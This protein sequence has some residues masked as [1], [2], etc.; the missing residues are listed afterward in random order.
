MLAEKSSLTF[1]DEVRQQPVA[2]RRFTQVAWEEYENS[3]ALEEL[4]GKGS[5]LHIVLT[6]IGSS[7]FACYIAMRFLQCKGI[8]AS[9]MEALELQKMPRA[10]FSGN[11][12]VIAV[13]QSG[14]S[15]EVVELLELLPPS[16][17]VIG[18]TNY[19]QSRLYRMATIPLL[20]HAGAEYFTSSKSYTNTLAAVL[21]LA[22]RIAGCG[23]AELQE[24]RNQMELCSARMDA[25]I[26]DETLSSGVARF[27]G[28]VHF[29]ICVGSGYS[30]TTACH[31]EIVAEEAG[32][33]YSSR[34]TPAQFI[35][36]PIELIQP[37]FCVIIYDS[38]PV[39]RGKCDE[40]RENV[41]R[42]GGKVLLITNRPDIAP[43]ENQ[44][45]CVI[46]HPDPATAVLVEILPLEL[47][48]DRLCKSRGIATGHL[49][50]VVKR[51][52][53]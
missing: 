41:L 11:T 15:P 17:P 27:I 38:N 47:G 52:A 49:S 46:P 13:S 31:S 51:L 30:Y 16:V 21:L 42:Y 2:L 45:V 34:Y 20:I 50:R 29:L 36:G 37:G 19:P 7:L 32:K 8:Q 48:I 18:V 39:Y 3:R 9:T 25:L 14:E 40:V 33:F 23:E 24:L 28:D 53:N 35:H 12:V 5:G 6:G 4:L 44:M 22:H 26:A 10:F 1:L 43:R